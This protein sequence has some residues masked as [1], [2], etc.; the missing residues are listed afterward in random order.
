MKAQILKIAGVNNEQDFYKKFPTQKAFMAKHGAA[1]K[2]L[3]KAQAGFTGAGG[4]PG[5]FANT[6]QYGLPQ[7]PQPNQPQGMGMQGPMP[8]YS[9]PTS[10]D[11][12]ELLGIESLKGTPSIDD[13]ISANQ[14][15]IGNSSTGAASKV[16]GM[17]MAGGITE[18]INTI[19][20]VVGGVK[21]LNAEKKARKSAE[22]WKKVSDV[23]LKAFNTPDV[24]ERT[25]I[26]DTAKRERKALMPSVN[27]EALFPT[28][29]VGTN[30]LA[31]AGGKLPTGG[32]SRGNDY[33]SKEHPYPSVS[34]GD[35]A[36][37]GR[38]Y[39]IP[40]KQDAG[41]A[42]RLASLH[43]RPDVKAKVYAKYPELRKANYGEIMNTYVP[44][45][46][47]YSD[48]GYEPL[49]ESEPGFQ[50][51]TDDDIIK[52]YRGG[53]LYHRAQSGM[54][55]SSF[56]GSGGG[57]P[58]ES[59]FNSASSLTGA[60]TGNNAGGDIGGGIGGGIGYGAGMLLGGPLGAS[61]GKAAGNFLGSTVG[62]LLDTNPQKTKKA[63]EAMMRN[64]GKM[65]GISN[66]RN[67]LGGFHGVVE[68]G[69][70]MSHNW[71]PQVIT[72]FG[73]VDVSDIHDK[74]Y[75][76]MKTLRTGGNIRTNE[77][78]DIEA[79]SGGHL[80]PMSYNPFADGSGYTSM[81]KGQSHD[82]SNGDHTGV[83]LNYK[84][85]DGGEMGEPQVEAERGEPIK[86]IGNNAVIFGDIKISKHTTGNDP[87]FAKY[88]G[89]TFKKAMEDVA[90]NDKKLN[91]KQQK[92][93]KALAEINPV[94]PIDKLKFNSLSLNEKGINEKYKRNNHLTQKASQYQELINTEAESRGVDAGALSRG[95]FKPNINM[96]AKAGDKL[97]P[98]DTDPPKGSRGNINPNQVYSQP[99][100]MPGALDQNPIGPNN[101]NEMFRSP[102]AYAQYKAETEKAYD[103]PEIAKQLV[104]YFLTY[105]GPDQAD[106]R[107]KMNQQPTYADMVATAR[108]LATDAQPGRYHINTDR[109]R[110][111][112]GEI[113]PTTPETP[114]KDSIY[115]VTPYKKT[116]WETVAGQLLP[117]F[118]KQP[119]ENLLGDQLSGEM[120]ALGNNRIEPVQAR[121]YHPEL[122]VPYDI[123]LQD[124]M[125]ANQADFN[126]LVKASGNNPAAL[127]A[128][129]SQKYG[130]NSNVL[131]EQFRLNQAKKDQVYSGNR[132]TLN[133]AQMRNLGLMDQQYVRQEEAK[134]RTKETAQEALNSIA[135]KIGQ[136]RLENRTLQTYS[137]MFPDFSF[138]KSYRTRHTGAP[139]DFNM[140]IVYNEKGQPTHIA[141]YDENGK[142]SGYKKIDEE[143]ITSQIPPLPN[144]PNKGNKTTKTT[145]TDKT[146]KSESTKT[147]IYRHG[148][149]VK[150][151]KNI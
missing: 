81:I 37:G 100:V 94:T 95:K 34:K 77:V 23:S 144:V 64:V 69:G 2:K 11:P 78:G 98:V 5:Y 141:E 12:N 91:D 26:A 67:F 93:T 87:D 128:L 111:P 68:D 20:D 8:G 123:S 4:Y 28:Y 47:I 104:N 112:A 58:W 21:A 88:Y 140:P 56:V 57:A 110:K 30:V 49:G 146:G 136:N 72:K 85:Q 92:N 59:M 63:Q 101:P 142:I 19:S 25:T 151:F 15:T 127:A 122:D 45:T 75:S 106:V 51:L 124:Q 80:E 18:G 62:G 33:G 108:K 31:K 44:P 102:E 119:G 6:P 103:D 150:A 24:N 97:P 46:D 137:N 86:E 107:A 60:A 79:V 117:W 53:G 96:K 14:Q 40:T 145:K 36:G 120:F 42:L 54:D 71:N 130:A 43:H 149:L 74:F 32:L 147:E 148:N 114:T 134:S 82:E 125:N 22:A 48:G 52:A 121:F 61:L 1:F 76:D 135:S 99:G 9:L 105:E 50:P 70:Y 55:F 132:A 66:T 13:T 7:Y 29:G 35:F 38:S 3:Q 115:D 17:D 84:A 143:D 138:D 39:P 131:G 113:T 16:P 65:S 73:D 126:Q 89:K 27:A 133:D 139:A 129:A 118:R 116:G 10:I 109:F 83:L 41:D 90:K